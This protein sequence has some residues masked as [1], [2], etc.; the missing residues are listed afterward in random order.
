MW[1]PTSVFRGAERLLIDS[2]S[3]KA[4]AQGGESGYDAGKKVKGRKRHLLVDVIGLILVLVVTP[5]S[6]QDRDGAVPVLEQAALEH[7]SLRKVWA[8]GAYHGRAIDEARARTNIEIEMVKRSDD[9]K[10]FVVLPRRWVVERTFG[11]LER[12]RLLT[13]EYERTIT[14]SEADVFHAMSMIM[15]RRLVRTEV[16]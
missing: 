14:S 7:S 8:D 1:F 2:Q 11:W 5:A 4:S 9:M 12:F 10:G 13:R 15:C 3:V 16:A 6:V